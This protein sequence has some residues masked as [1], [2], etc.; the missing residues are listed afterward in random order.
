MT[1]KGFVGLG[2]KTWLSFGGR[3][4]L[5]EIDVIYAWDEVS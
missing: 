4:L 2:W 5:R 3:I 1:R